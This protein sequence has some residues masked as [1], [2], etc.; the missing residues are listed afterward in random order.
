MTALRALGASV[1]KALGPWARA[2]RLSNA[3]AGRTVTPSAH[4]IAGSAWRRLLAEDESD[5]ARVEAERGHPARREALNRQIAQAPSAAALLGLSRRSLRDFD[6][7][8][9]STCLR[10]LA[11]L[12]RGLTP[13]LLD[14]EAL[15]ELAQ[16]QRQDLAR[17]RADG[18]GV[19]SAAWTLAKLGGD[20]PLLLCALPELV[21]AAAATA[22][23]MSAQVG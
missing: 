4:P 11:L 18:F 10:R 9:V 22:R 12:R 8:H 19:A 23:G 7:V 13:E 21:A 17:G 3:V 5:A 20:A 15:R 6:S 1:P 14:G 16:A 2:R